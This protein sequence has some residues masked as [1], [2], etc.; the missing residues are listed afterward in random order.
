MLDVLGGEAAADARG[1]RMGDLHGQQIEG[2][3]P[4]GR[5]TLVPLYHPAAGLYNPG[6]KETMREDFRGLAGYVDGCSVS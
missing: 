3:L 2:T 1:A 6:L 4:Y 5:V